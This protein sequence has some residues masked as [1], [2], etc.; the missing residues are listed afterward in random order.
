MRWTGLIFLAFSLFAQDAEQVQK[1]VESIYP[2]NNRL[3]ELRMGDI[4]RELRIQE[5]SQVA[6]VGCGPG[7]ISVILSHVVGA[8]GKVYCEDVS[9]SKDFGL[10]HAKANMKKQHVKNVTLVH[11]DTENPKLPA[12][13]LDAVLIVNAYHEMLKYQSMLQHIHDALKS[14]GRLVIVD[15]NPNRTASRPRE[16]QTN[17]HVLSPDL[18]APE[19]QAAGFRIVDRQDGFIANPDAESS[20]W[21]IAAERP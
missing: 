6:D 13:S 10:A 15:N 4:A 17:N 5:G 21:L 7:D 3:K 2:K 11:G 16:K 9:D 19:I 20:H 8:N 1:T 12:G 18:A 14:G